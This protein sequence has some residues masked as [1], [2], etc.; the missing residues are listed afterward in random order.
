[1]ADKHNATYHGAH[2]CGDCATWWD[3]TAAADACCQ[4]D[5]LTGFDPSRNR[6]SYRLSYD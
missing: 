1:M 6:L 5:G 3:S 2:Q 4:D